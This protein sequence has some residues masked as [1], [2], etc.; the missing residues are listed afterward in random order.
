[1]FARPVLRIEDV[2]SARVHGRDVRYVQKIHVLRSCPPDPILSCARY[3]CLHGSYHLTFPS[4]Q[5]I[6]Y[7]GLFSGLAGCSSI[8]PLT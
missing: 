6:L 2:M 1:M 3:L 7:I 8:T 4:W 5:H